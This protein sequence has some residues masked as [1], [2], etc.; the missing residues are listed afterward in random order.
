MKSLILHVLCAV[1]SFVFL[2]QNCFAVTESLAVEE[3]NPGSNSQSL[4][5]RPALI[6]T[7]KEQ[8]VLTT[9]GWIS[10]SHLRTFRM[11]LNFAVKGDLESQ[12]M[13]S[14]LYGLLEREPDPERSFAWCYEAALQGHLGAQFRLVGKYERGE[15]I[16]QNVQEARLWEDRAK[17]IYVE[18]ERPWQEKVSKVYLQELV[19]CFRQIHKEKTAKL[20]SDATRFCEEVEATLEINKSE[21]DSSLIEGAQKR[22]SS[23][24]MQDKKP[25]SSSS[26]IKKLA[27]SAKKKKGASSRKAKSLRKEK[28]LS[29]PPR[30]T[31]K[32]V[33]FKELSPDRVKN[34]KS[35]EKTNHF[36][37]F[38]KMGVSLFEEV[39]GSA[40]NTLRSAKESFGSLSS[41]YVGS[42]SPGSTTDEGGTPL[43]RTPP[44]VSLQ[45]KARKLWDNFSPD[46]SSHSSSV[47]TDEESSP[48]SRDF[49]FGTLQKKTRSLWS[50]S[51]L[52]V[53]S[54]SSS[55]MTDG[56]KSSLSMSTPVLEAPRR[57]ETP[58]SIQDQG[59]AFSS[60][61]KGEMA[62][63]IKRSP[64]RG[65]EE[66]RISDEA[67][68][69]LISLVRSFSEKSGEAREFLGNI[70]ENTRSSM[71][72]MSSFAHSPGLKSLG[73]LFGPATPDVK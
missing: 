32:R 71:S 2:S 50:D 54:H 4:K 61:K 59:T 55:I 15:G 60:P 57:C 62:P 64:E 24:S 9:E 58:E 17:K 11:Y 67:P 68:K 13:M 69:A 48:T 29:S 28:V 19:E 40:K 47:M 43:F 1:S 3:E 72:G 65:Q 22:G 12:F 23:K 66:V 70:V 42:E 8:D 51:S 52:R 35:S 21:D 36:I 31:I 44:F 37:Q 18:Q 56:D 20:I 73:S 7:P 6:L 5:Q 26:K 49:S 14:T 63:K 53:S 45:E 46:G 16:A 30:K 33:T 38:P 27:F 41:L 39:C 10:D 34:L 25:T